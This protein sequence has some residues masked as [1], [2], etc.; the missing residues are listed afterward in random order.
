MLIGSMAQ[1]CFGSGPR[2]HR[3]E[4]HCTPQVLLTDQGLAVETPS[5]LAPLPAIVLE[6]VLYLLGVVF[7]SPTGTARK[8]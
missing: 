3:P 2:F 6:E 7:S 5:F 8:G 1:T 4:F